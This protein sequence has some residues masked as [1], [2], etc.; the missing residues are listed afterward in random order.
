MAFSGTNFRGVLY[1][2]LRYN[3][4]K[5]LD[6]WNGY[7]GVITKPVNNSFLNNKKKNAGLCT[8]YIDQPS[9]VSTVD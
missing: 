2:Y 7:W 1:L 8:L 3:K 4:V 5:H 6:Q 9:D